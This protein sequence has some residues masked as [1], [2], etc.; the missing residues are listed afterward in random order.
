NILNKLLGSQDSVNSKAF[1]EMMD[2]NNHRDFLLHHINRPTKRTSPPCLKSVSL[3]NDPLMMFEGNRISRA[4]ATMEASYPM[5][6]LR[7]VSLGNDAVMFEDK[8]VSRASYLEDNP[9]CVS[10]LRW[11]LASMV[12]TYGSVNLVAKNQMGSRLLQRLV[13]E[14]RFLDALFIEVV[15]HVVEL[16]MDPFG[17]YIIQKTQVVQTMIE[18]VKTSQQIEMVKSSIKSGF[19]HLVNDMNGNHVILSCLKSL[20]PND[21]KV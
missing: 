1:E 15:N 9:N 7:G 12:N 2:L 17:N 6:N 8:R 19:L 20:G 3:E 16:S 13:D 4:P 21:Y 5:K 10:G 18:K 11:E 14:A